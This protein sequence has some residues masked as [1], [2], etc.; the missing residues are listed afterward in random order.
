MGETEETIRVADDLT[1]GE[2]AALAELLIAV[3][4]AVGIAV[5]VYISKRRPI[6]IGEAN[7]QRTSAASA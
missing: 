3:V 7:D 4:A 6:A 2:T 5:A 1:D